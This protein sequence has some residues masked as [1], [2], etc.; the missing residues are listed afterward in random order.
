MC[1]IAVSIGHVDAAVKAAVERMSAAQIHRGPDAGAIWSS[2]PA[3]G[4][5]GVVLAHRRLSIIDLSTDANQPMHDERT[6]NVLVFNGEIYGFE[7]LR[8][9]LRGLGSSFRTRSDTEVLLR[10][11]AVWGVDCLKRLRGMFA[12]ALWDP[13]RRMLLVARD[14]VG[15]KPLYYAR[16]VDSEGRATILFG[17]E[18][19]ALLASGCIERRLSPEALA[20][21]AWNGF[22][23]GEQ[24]AV[25]GV[26]SL[27]AGHHAVVGLDGELPKPERY[28]SLPMA[29]GTGVDDLEELRSEL[30]CA[31]RQHLI[32]D[33]PMGVFLSGGIDSSALAALA[34]RA[35]R[36]RIC[37]F[38][39]AFDDPRFD[40]S[41]YARRVAEGLGTEHHEIRLSES[42]F[43]A[44]LDAALASLDQ[45]SFD[46]INTYF[47]SR[48]VREAGITVALAGTGGDEL[49]GGY[50]SFQEIPRG[51]RIARAAGLVP[52]PVLRRL[53]GVVTRVAMGA[54]GAVPPQTRWGKLEDALTTRGELVDVYQVS[55]ALYSERFLAELVE[56][57][58]LE[59]V[60]RGLT[61]ERRKSLLAAID[62]NTGLR[63]ISALEV[64]SFLGQ[65]LLRDTD[66]ASMA[67]SLEVRV[68]L[69]DHLVIESVWRLSER[70]RFLPL[71]RK[72]A[73]RE[74]ALGGL[75]PS[76]F[77]R[78]K[79]GFVL[80][81]DRWAREGMQREVA[82]T[83][84][85]RDACRSVGLVPE[86][87]ARLWRAFEAGAPGIYWSRVW[88]IFALLRWCAEH[89]VGLSGRGS[90]APSRRM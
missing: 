87:V 60:V 35:G 57:D 11:Y 40:E 82:D 28:W 25:I 44:Q 75:D 64:S 74:V 9:E 33:V 70:R 10:A 47:V 39:I 17:S 58:L 63:A 85:D 27:P 72:Q 81:I 50:R 3:D 59:D 41:V 8:D 1:G 14:R 54:P 26:R 16:V 36:G 2:S 83:L 55:Y 84:N 77:E 90:R 20:T 22:I 51:C 13:T 21:Y 78:P 45:P 76:I 46:A 66:A 79:S 56:R 62:G 43:R 30:E 68:P 48:A 53:A 23:N 6:G 80:P 34:S 19:R 31:T 71:G 86:T 52:R 29:S 4:S 37:T 61:S 89:S 69:L 18:L 5:R 24:T 42:T 49:F 38:T 67:V 12:F 15:I 7:E 88:S 73:L 65:R 32:S